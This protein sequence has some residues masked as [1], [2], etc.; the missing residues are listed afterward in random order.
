MS[1][2]LSVTARRSTWCRP[3]GAVP[4][5]DHRGAS[6]RLGDDGHPHPGDLPNFISGL[7]PSRA[8]PPSPR[9]GDSPADQ[10]RRPRYDREV[11]GDRGRSAG[12]R[13]GWGR[14]D[15]P[16]RCS[17]PMLTT[18]PDHNRIRREPILADSLK[19]QAQVSDGIRQ[20]ARILHAGVRVR[21]PLAPPLAPQVRGGWLGRN[22]RVIPETL[23]DG[24]WRSPVTRTLVRSQRSGKLLVLVGIGDRNYGPWGPVRDRG[25]PFQGL[26]L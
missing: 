11:G 1:V 26:P 2:R 23:A 22:T 4:P 12:R 13:R 15:E 17:W 25:Y 7:G 8:R 21:V 3:S 9:R 19:A 6:D 14:S 16:R 24:C 18:K 20:A 5:D 10:G